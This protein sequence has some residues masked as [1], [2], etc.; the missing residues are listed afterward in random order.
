MWEQTQFPEQI[1]VYMLLMEATGIWCFLQPPEIH[2]LHIHLMVFILLLPIPVLP[3]PI[4]ADTFLLP[5]QAHKT[6]VCREQLQEPHQ[7]LQEF[8]EAPQEQAVL[9]T[10]F[11]E[12]M[13]PH[14]IMQRE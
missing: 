1:T 2:L 11:G 6:L 7:M 8:M 5:E 10:E 9:Q 14:Q 13:H 3:I 12:T 4:L